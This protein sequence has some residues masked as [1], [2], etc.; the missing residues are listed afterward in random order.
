M[1]S[2]HAVG[3]DYH[4]TMTSRGHLINAAASAGAHVV[5]ARQAL[6]RCPLSAHRVADMVR[7]EARLAAAEAEQ[8]RAE[9]ALR[10]WPMPTMAQLEERARRLADEVRM[11]VADMRKIR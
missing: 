5:E 7:C 1:R 8:E 9:A 3:V 10:A 2:R 11:L 6:T 4:A